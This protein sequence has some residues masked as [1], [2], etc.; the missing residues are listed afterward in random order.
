[1]ISFLI[2]LVT[3]IIILLIRIAVIGI[4][5]ILTHEFG[6]YM[7][8]KIYG[9]NPRFRWYGS[10]PAVTHDRIAHKWKSISVNL[11]GMLTG[12]L[13]IILLRQYMESTEMFVMFIFGMIMASSYD[14][15][16]VIY[17]IKKDN[18]DKNEKKI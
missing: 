2:G 13:S 16:N 3:G 15:A 10:N 18:G 8:A 14:I 6:H 1:M 4:I 5:S 17:K 12:I 11:A 9:A 7:A